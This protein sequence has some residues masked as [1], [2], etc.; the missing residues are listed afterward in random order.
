LHRYL[1]AQSTARASLYFY[2][3]KEEIDSFIVSLLES[4]EFFDSIFS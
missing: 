3:T 2:N 1:K 4:I